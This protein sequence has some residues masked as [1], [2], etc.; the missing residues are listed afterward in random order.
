MRNQPQ[1]IFRLSFVGI[2][3]AAMLVLTAL[4]GQVTAQQNDAS[5]APAPASASS[6]VPQIIQFTGT[7]SGAPS[8]T[9]SITFTLYENEQG[10]TALWS[11]TDNV[12]LDAQGHY[13]A[14]LGSALPEG[15]PVKYLHRRPGPLAGR[16]AAVGRFR[17][18]AAGAAGQRALCVESRR[19]GNHRRLAALSL[20]AGGGCG[21]QSI[22][23]HFD[24]Q[25]ERYFSGRVQQSA[26]SRRCNRLGPKGLHTVMGQ[27]FQDRRFR[28]VS[29]GIG[30][31]RPGRRR[32]G[33][34][35]GPIGRKWRCGPAW[36]AHHGIAGHGHIQR[37][38]QLQSF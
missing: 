20:H 27:H 25:F 21:E 32:H 6:T 29:V 10:G 13:T 34:S 37:G 30:S 17:R 22:S 23:K 19:R 18:T 33:Y 24:R 5:T 9:V 12:Q 1:P 15:L 4:P 36:R 2:V 38:L 7:L 8:G 14:L 26:A 16:A 11:E 3:L 28:A 35:S 31:E